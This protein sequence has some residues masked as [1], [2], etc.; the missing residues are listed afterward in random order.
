MEGK[1]MTTKHWEVHPAGVATFATLLFSLWL[2]VTWGDVLAVL[3]FPVVKALVNIA[4]IGL[5]LAAV[6]AIITSVA[7]AVWK[8]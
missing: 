2:F 3:L 7:K 5:L 8:G 1:P 4:S 6:T